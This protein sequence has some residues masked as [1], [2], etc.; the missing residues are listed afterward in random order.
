MAAQHEKHFEHSQAWA[1]GVFE[2]AWVIRMR[3]QNRE[4]PDPAR[5]L[6]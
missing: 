6:W 3:H 2:A 1:L 4:F 5:T